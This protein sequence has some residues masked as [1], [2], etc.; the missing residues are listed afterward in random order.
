MSKSYSS[1]CLGICLYLHVLGFICLSVCLSVLLMV[2]YFSDE[3]RTYRQCTFLT[4]CV[5]LCLLVC[6]VTNFLLDN[7]HTVWKSHARVT[8]LCFDLFFFRE[9]VY[10]L[11]LVDSSQCGSQQST[12]QKQNVKERVCQEPAWA[13]P[14]AWDD[15]VSRRSLR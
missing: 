1:V 15:R 5:C 14:G 8:T 2:L 6:V 9:C 3:L 4:V 10:S 7:V 12:C 13:R 11:P